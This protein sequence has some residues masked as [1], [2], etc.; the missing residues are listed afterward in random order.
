MGPPGAARFL[1]SYG[2]QGLLTAQLTSAAQ[3]VAESKLFGPPLLAMTSELLKCRMNLVG[4]L[5]EAN[6]V[7]VPLRPACG[8]NVASARNSALPSIGCRRSWKF[9]WRR[10][11]P[12]KLRDSKD[13]HEALARPR[14]TIQLPS[15]LSS[16]ELAELITDVTT[17]LFWWRM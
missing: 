12:G 16:A 4:K 1:G 15:F 13:T 10:K 8:Q 7:P 5:N 6:E 17:L 11:S 9:W 3:D 14:R 2:A